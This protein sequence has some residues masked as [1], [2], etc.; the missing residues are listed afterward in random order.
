MPDGSIKAIATDQKTSLGG[1][2][3]RIP[4]MAWLGLKWVTI[5]SLETLGLALMLAGQVAFMGFLR[6]Y[7]RYLIPVS[8]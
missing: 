8:F 5:L 3:M 4:R 2:S 1:R 7:N 6:A